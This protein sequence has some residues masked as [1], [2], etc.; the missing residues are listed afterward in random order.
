M[1]TETQ[2]PQNAGPIQT[3]RDGAV[4]VK[5]WRQE[6][7][8]GPFVTATLGRT[9]QDKQTQEFKES[10]SLGGAD[11]LKAQALLIEANREMVQWRRYFK[12]LQAQQAQVRPQTTPNDMT[13]ARDAA[14]A[15]AKAPHTAAPQMAPAPAP[16]PSP[17]Q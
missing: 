12:E 16:A 5:L 8:N 17:E 13:T 6:S 4:V 15:G 10:R 2:T 9:Y 11:V 7:Q 14:L 3:L 1:T